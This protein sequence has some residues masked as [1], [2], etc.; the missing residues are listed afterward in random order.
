MNLKT[1]YTKMGKGDISFIYFDI[2]SNSIN[3]ELFGHMAGVYLC[4][5][6]K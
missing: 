4:K 5:S 1:H 3:I 2:S 6:R